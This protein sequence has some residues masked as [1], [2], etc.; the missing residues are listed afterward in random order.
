MVEELL[1]H[2]ENLRSRMEDLEQGDPE[3]QEDEEEEEEE[4]EI[5]EPHHELGQG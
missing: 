4:E 1:K 5:G 3:Y 2:N